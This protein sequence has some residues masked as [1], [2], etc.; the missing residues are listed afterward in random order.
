MTASYLCFSHCNFRQETCTN[1]PLLSCHG[2]LRVVWMLRKAHFWWNPPR[3]PFPTCSYIILLCIAY[4]VKPV[5]NDHS[6]VLDEIVDKVR[7]LDK[8]WSSPL[9]YS[10]NIVCR[11]VPTW[12]FFCWS[13]S[14]YMQYFYCTLVDCSIIYP[15]SLLYPQFYLEWMCALNHMYAYT[16]HRWGN[17]ISKV[18]ICEVSLYCDL[19]RQVVLVQRCFSAT[20]LGNEPVY[21]GLRV[22][23]VFICE[24]SHRFSCIEWYSVCALTKCHYVKW[25][26]A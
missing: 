21:C 23:V 14:T 10:R 11:F 13:K 1:P 19:C 6:F 9:V 20:E 18:Q 15:I 4:T 2:A 16:Q 8:W 24:W 22:Q 3:Y 17:W 5:Y 7:K 25:V 26:K 12:M